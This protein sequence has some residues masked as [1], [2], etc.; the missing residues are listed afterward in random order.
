MKRETMVKGDAHGG[1]ANVLG[2]CGIV[3]SFG[4]GKAVMFQVGGVSVRHGGQ[5]LGRLCEVSFFEPQRQYRDVECT[6]GTEVLE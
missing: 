6:R 1:G 3:P 2:R 5:R 4:I